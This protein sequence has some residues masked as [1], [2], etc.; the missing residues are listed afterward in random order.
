MTQLAAPTGLDPHW[1]T[2]LFASSRTVCRAVGDSSRLSPRA[3]YQELLY[4][5]ATLLDIRPAPE[6]AARGEIHPEL[7]PVTA[8]NDGLPAPADGRVIVLCAEGHASLTVVETMR[9][10]GHAAVTDVEGGFRAW[11]ELGLPTA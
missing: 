5:R 6:R 7:R 4:G 1:Q 3:A 9:R 11:R 2:Q 10:Q 8:A